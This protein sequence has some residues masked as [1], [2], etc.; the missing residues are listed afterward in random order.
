MSEV[1]AEYAVVRANIF[2]IIASLI[3]IIFL[4]V[5]VHTIFFKKKIY[6][7]P[8]IAS[9]NMANC[10]QGTQGKNQI[11]F[12]CNVD[13]K[14]TID[15]QSYSANLTKVQNTKLEAGKTLEV[16]YEKNKPNNVSINP[17]NNSNAY[18]LL[19]V[20]ALLVGGA[21]LALYFTKKYKGFATVSGGIQAVGD[22]TS[23]FRGVR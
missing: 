13:V 22:V 17:D 12:S 18:A 9:I 10:I 8:V 6:T 2:L 14:Y 19:I 20:G 11:S 3:A 16:Y 5:S 4:F 1:F 21:Y 7:E 23:I 15:G